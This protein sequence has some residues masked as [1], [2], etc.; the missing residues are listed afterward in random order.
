[1]IYELL[2]VEG[3]LYFRDY[4]HNTSNDKRTQKPIPIEEMEAFFQKHIKATPLL[5]LETQTNEVNGSNIPAIL[6]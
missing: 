2:E 1:L 5:L 6:G 3:K 4:H